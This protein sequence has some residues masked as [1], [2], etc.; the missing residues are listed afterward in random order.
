MEQDIDWGVKMLRNKEFR[1]FVIIISLVSAFIIIIGFSISTPCGILS[2]VSIFILEILFFLFTK[3]RYKKLAQISNQIDL[4]LH[5]DEN[6]SIVEFDEGEIS[7]LQSEIKKMIIHIF[8]Q[9]E[10][11]KKEKENLAHSLA[12]IAHQLRTPL[13]SVSLIL[14]LLENNN[15]ENERKL[16]IRETK[17]LFSQMDWLLTS[18]LKLSRLDA[19]IVIFKNEHIN[20]HNFLQ[21]AI[22]TFLIP[23]DIHNIYL[24][25]DV[26]K[27]IF[28]LG[29][30]NWL[31]EAIKNIIKNCMESIGDNGK[32]EISCTDNPLFTQIMIHDNGKGFD[33]KD[34]ACLFDRFYR[35]KNSSASG[36]GIGL[37]L[38]KMIISKQG[39]SITAKNHPNGGALF[40]IRFPK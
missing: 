14:S 1:N 16:L 39:G 38:C 13:T 24:K 21:S 8:E 35:G 30:S 27:N 18:L 3:E 36:Y 6:L 9:N 20:V 4:V 31:S 40:S 28:I 37:A 25:M 10:E 15:N 17:E 33:Q 29:D 7:I 5:N 19:G 22:R 32:I 12:D 23:I 11:L 2:S 26:P 34:L